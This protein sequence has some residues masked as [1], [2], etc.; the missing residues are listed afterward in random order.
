MK[1]VFIRPKVLISKCIEFEACRY[2]AQM[3]KNDTVK[4]LKKYADFITV[5]PE[6]QIGRP[7]P[8]NPIITILS[9][10]K[11][12]LYQNSS[13]RY[14]TKE[15]QKFTE[16]YLKEL[17][18]VDGIILKS[19]S[20]SCGIADVKVYNENEKL[21]IGRKDTGFF[22][23]GI[24]KRFKNYPIENEGRLQNRQTRDRFLTFLFAM[25]DFRKTH[26]KGDINKLIKYHSRNKLL[27]MAYNQSIMRKM[28][29]IIAKYN[30]GDIETVFTEY[31]TLL[32]TMF[33]KTSRY[34]NEINVLMYAFDY[35][36][37][38]INERERRLFLKTVEDFRMKYVTRSVP[39]ALL[40][41]YIERFEVSY[42]ME[43]T[44]FNRY[45]VELNKINSE[46]N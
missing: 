27:M 23:S 42:L 9:K 36:S 30:G 40:K 34:T 41:S 19:K 26:S 44:Y 29:N 3:V 2:D 43:Q 14:F 45:P 28:G 33:F 5:C 15:M 6:V 12:H 22:A 21:F 10:Q 32:R 25:A 37:K 20:P 13:N 35:I 24:L 4:I 1:N 18:G 46:E 11:K 8:R 17:K 31:E 39:A 7:I 16:N 38:K